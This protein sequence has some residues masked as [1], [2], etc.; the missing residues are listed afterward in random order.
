VMLKLDRPI[1][2]IGMARAGTALLCGLVNWHSQVGPR[3]PIMTKY[4]NCQDFIDRLYGN[5]KGHVWYSDATEHKAWF[6]KYFPG[7][8]NW[9]HMGNE[10]I[11]E[12][13]KLTPAQHKDLIEGV[14]RYW[15]SEPRFIMKSPSV[16]FIASLLPKIFGDDVKIVCITRD[17]KG[18]DRSWRRLAE[19][20]FTRREKVLGYSITEKKW[21]ETKDYIKRLKKL[22]IQMYDVNFNDL[23]F[24]TESVLEGVLRYCELPVEPY[25]YGVKLKRRKK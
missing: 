4:P 16:T 24:N 12:E 9:L 3:M 15:E 22:G 23:I 18:V 17:L 1:V 2:I 25:I 5:S 19:E 13:W 8:S 7:G 21:K 6:F 20:S 10:L 14:T 11:E